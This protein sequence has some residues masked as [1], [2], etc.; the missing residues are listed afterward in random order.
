[1]SMYNGWVPY[2]YTRHCPLA[3]LTSYG[4]NGEDYDQGMSYSMYDQI[5]FPTSKRS[6]FTIWCNTCEIKCEAVC[7]NIPSFINE[8]VQASHV[9]GMHPIFLTISSYFCIYLNHLIHV[10]ACMEWTTI[11][12]LMILIGKCQFH[13]LGTWITKKHL[14]K[15]SNSFHVDFKM[16]ATH[17]PYKSTYINYIVKQV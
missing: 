13:E 12:T 15:F 16:S 5:I 3:K 10:K 9:K 4:N 17:T 8:V 6:G 2:Q 7:I 11:S 1:M 14:W